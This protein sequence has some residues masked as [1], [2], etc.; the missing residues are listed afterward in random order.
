[1]PPGDEGMARPLLRWHR[2]E[3]DLVAVLLNTQLHAVT[4]WGKAP[5]IIAKAATNEW[6]KKRVLH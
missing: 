4:L 5:D 2:A 3:Q 6:Q 1:M